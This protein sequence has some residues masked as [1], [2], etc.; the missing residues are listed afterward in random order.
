M[1]PGGRSFIPLPSQE[2]F[3]DT[4]NDPAKDCS[5]GEEGAWD[6][7][8]NGGKGEVMETAIRWSPSSSISEQRFLIADVVGRTFKLCKVNSYDGEKLQYQKI[9]THNKV[10]QF[11]AFDWSPFDESLIAVGQWTGEATILR[12][13][14]SSQD[15]LSLPIKHQRV[16]NAVAFSTNGLLAAGLERVRNDFCL[17]VFDINQRLGTNSTKGFGSERQPVEP[18]RKLASS[19]VITSIKFFANQPDTLVTGVKGSCLR[20]YDVRETMGSPSLQLQTRCVHN[21]AI[22]PLDENY[23]ASASPQGETTV[24]IWDRRS[25]PRLTAASLGSGAKNEVQDGSVLELKNVIDSTSSVPSVIWSLR[26]SKSRRGCLGILA[27]TG[28]Y[29]VFDIAKKYM[30]SEEH[31]KRESFQREGGSEQDIEQVYVKSIQHVAYPHYD[32]RYGSEE[33][34]R[35]VSFDFTNL[36]G[37]KGTPCAI[38]LRGDKEI[39]ICELRGHPP[40]F[41]VSSKGSIVMGETRVTHRVKRQLG[42]EGMVP[43]A[44]SVITPKG[45]GDVGEARDSVRTRTAADNRSGLHASHN[46]VRDMAG[47]PPREYYMSSRKAHEKLHDLGPAT[48]RLNIEDALASSTITRRRCAEGYLFD[49]DRNAR[50]VGNNRWLQDLWTWIGREYSISTVH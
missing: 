12:I 49:C 50:I 27:S 42:E 4:I 34:K 6:D 35:I 16:C 38:T 40:P 20:I 25:G 8:I 5:W 24:N 19:E 17:N 44:F 11:R 36:A 21:L 30:S 37:V 43:K 10:P 1:S 23:F 14:E 31:E 41:T 7:V 32:R 47:F 9:A 13:D 48:S 39:G 33:N 22:D 28:Q 2:R 26:Y 3:P 29:K 15:T 18:M 46:D 45:T